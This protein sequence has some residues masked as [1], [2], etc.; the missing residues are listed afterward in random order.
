MISSKLDS[1]P[2]SE[3]GF[4]LLEMLVVLAIL[5][6]AYSLAP[7]MFSSGVS[8][9]ELKSA[10]RQLAA[11]LRKA[12]GHAIQVRRDATLTVDVE[13]RRFRISGDDKAYPLPAKAELTVFTSKA[14]AEGERSGAIRFHPDGSS[15]G[16]RITVASG[17][18][19][20]LVDV[21]WLTG[22]VEILE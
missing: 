1:P 5:G 14:D 6:F 20:F 7:P 13:Q 19:K 17:E 4:T 21:E 18:R 9:T 22:R 12:R 2:G 3:R 15:T 16:G 8:T 11:G 10:A